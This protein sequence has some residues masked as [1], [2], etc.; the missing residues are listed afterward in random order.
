MYLSTYRILFHANHCTRNLRSPLPLSREKICKISIRKFPCQQLRKKIRADDIS[1]VG[2]RQVY[3]V[4]IFST[5]R[6][7][8]ANS[9]SSLS[10]FRTIRR[11]KKGRKG[12]AERVKSKHGKW[13]RRITQYG[14]IRA[15]K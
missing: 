2:T 4:A 1:R 5:R 12:G 6:V 13:E 15:G 7:Q 14:Y 10:L 11:K 8:F 9:L 3:F